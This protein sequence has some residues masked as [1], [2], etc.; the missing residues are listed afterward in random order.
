VPPSSGSQSIAILIID[1]VVFI[2]FGAILFRYIYLS[3]DTVGVL[4]WIIKFPF[5]FSEDPLFRPMT[6]IGHRCRE[7]A[8]RFFC[9]FRKILYL[10]LNQVM[11]KF[12]DILS[13]SSSPSTVKI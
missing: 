11:T 9:P 4:I 5:P 10:Y 8:Y 12:F 7:F 6:A 2:L 13:N 1:F 3:L